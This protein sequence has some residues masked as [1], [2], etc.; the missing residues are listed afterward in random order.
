MRK[1]SLGLKGRIALALSLSVAGVVATQAPAI[2]DT[3]SNGHIVKGAIE[4]E[5][6]RLGPDNVGWAVTD[7]LDANYLG[8]FQ[9]FERPAPHMGNSIYWHNDTG[10]H[11]VGGLIR[12]KY[13]D[14]GWESGDLHFPT[15]S[16]TQTPIKPGAFNHFQGGSIYYSSSTGAWPTWGAIRDTWANAGWENSGYGFPKSYEYNCND[17][18]N[19]NDKSWNYGGKGQDYQGGRIFWNS[20]PNNFNLPYSSVHG[21]PRTLK[22]SSTTKYTSAQSNAISQWNALGRVNIEP[23][24]VLNNE[25][26]VVRDI[27]R[28]DYTWAGLYTYRGADF[29]TLEMN[30]AKFTGPSDSRI[31]RVMTHEWGHS[32]GLAH[33]CVGSNMD[34]LIYFNNNPNLSDLDKSSYNTKHP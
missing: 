8:K 23:A 26:L 22:Y 30:D 13:R 31:P 9:V 12:D 1:K 28:S 4:A 34:E 17:G 15:T 18:I 10:A 19:P 21:S 11:Q 25:V 32:L 29:S 7:E 27:N 6:L 24:T 33:S 16:E 5:W 3:W 20:A 2:A 14:L